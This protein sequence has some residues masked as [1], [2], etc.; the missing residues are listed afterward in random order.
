MENSS[1]LLNTEGLNYLLCMYKE[2]Y[3]VIFIYKYRI[4]GTTLG[5]SNNLNNQYN[6]ITKDQIQSLQGMELNRVA[7]ISI[8]E[9]TTEN[10]KEAQEFQEI[11]E[12]YESYSWGVENQLEQEKTFGR[13]HRISWKQE[14]HEGQSQQL[15]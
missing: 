8:Q 5:Q 15:F 6:Y 10:I 14:F 12:R 4:Q 3:V 11:S 2:I 7:K 1:F 13:T 9:L